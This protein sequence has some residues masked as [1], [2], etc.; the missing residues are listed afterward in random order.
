VSNEADAEPHVT[1]IIE[2]NMAAK[3]QEIGD[4]S[5]VATD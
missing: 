3:D 2:Q 1:A 4:Q 5:S